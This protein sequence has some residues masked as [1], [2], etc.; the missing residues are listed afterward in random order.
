[1]FVFENSINKIIQLSGRIILFNAITFSCF[2]QTYF[3]DNYG[4][5]QGLESSKVFSIVQAKDDYIW[6]GTKAGV[7]K[8]NG[9][10]FQNYTIEDGLAKGGVRVVY[11]DKTGILWF[12][13]E[14][15]G[16]TRYDGKKF[17]N[18]NIT[19]TLPNLN[20]TSIVLT[21]DNNLWIC[22]SGDGVYRIFNPFDDFKKIKYEHFKGKKLGDNIFNSL[23]SS[24][25]DL[26]FITDYGIRKYMPETNSFQTYIP[27]GMDTYFAISILFEDSKKNLWFGTYNGGL[28]KHEYTS[29]NFSIIDTKAGLATNWISDITE[30]IY[31]NIWTGHWDQFDKGGISKIDTSGNITVFNTSNGMHDN[32][33]WC[34]IPDKEGNMLIGTTEHGFEIFKGEHFIS[35]TTEDGL[36]N[37]QVYAITQD[38][39]GKYWFGTKGGISVFD[40]KNKTF[41]NYNQDTR[42]ISNQIRFLK[43][44]SKGNLWIGTADQGIIRYDTKKKIF[45]Y[46]Q[47]IT[48][49]FYLDKPDNIPFEI[50]ALEIDDENN[51]WI[52][53]IERPLFY[54][55]ENNT[56]T[57]KSQEDGLP[58]NSITA[59]YID[60]KNRLWVGMNNK[61]IARNTKKGTNFLHVKSVGDITPTC[62]TEDKTGNIWIGT[63]SNGIFVLDDTTLIS[64]FTIH[65]GLL[66]NLINFLNVDE[67]NNIYV[68]TNIGLNKI[69][70]KENKIITYTKKSGFTGIESRDN[71]TFTDNKGKLWFGTGNG[72]ICYDPLIDKKPETEPLTHISNLLVNGEERSVTS[73]LNL[74][75]TEK[76]IT[77]VY[78]S[79]CL[80]DP[81]AVRYRIRLDGWETEWNDMGTQNSQIYSLPPGKYKF[82]V[83]AKNNQGIWNKN[84]ASLSFRI[85][86]PFYKSKGFII[87]TI[88]VLLFGFFSFIKIRERNLVREKKVLEDRVLER[89]NDLRKAN[90]QLAIRNKD[91]TDS[92]KYA[93][94]I[95]FSI[96]P[97]EIPFNNTFIFFKPKDIVSGD[98]YWLTSFKNKDFIAAVDCT[99]HGVPGAFMSFIGYTLLNKIVIENMVLEP[100]QILN[101]L[102]KEVAMTLHQKGEDIV[103]D[104]MDIALVCYDKLTQELEFAG[105][106]NPLWLMRKGELIEIKANR[107]AIGRLT[108]R[109]KEFTNHKLKIEPDDTI[110]LFSDGYC[111]QFGGPEGKKYKSGK[112]KELL[113]S[114]NQKSI[115]EQAK[116]LESSFE[117]WRGGHDQIDDVLFIGRRF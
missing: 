78:S 105:A 64:R 39:E 25:G 57:E 49:F 5:E 77:I 85:G 65:E 6:L 102:N 72:V 111:D 116:I 58:G 86:P 7:S 79:I 59:L 41:V 19:D 83:S 1:M 22:T 90:D 38:D 48:R 27:K 112:L 51:L 110:Y 75:H 4:S 20:V 82:N 21:S 108:G 50:T 23:V 107:F 43:K 10:S 2:A 63:A 69:K 44:D 53:T 67:E 16:I 114:I 32:K 100:G 35:F 98:F 101:Q 80:T 106:F 104:G 117:E 15:G 45:E 28:Y 17:E 31:G 3:F 18:L 103:N 87:S 55:I 97:P 95:Q 52:G 99:G 56:V 68:G 91:I 30:D 74:S 8:F 26:F 36:I 33:V 88:F 62:I 76:N 81:E 70:I 113:V 46:M 73:K 92:I 96:L 42:N 60:S 54:D 24:N 109:E 11:E 14:G 61:G 12:G 37:N 94:R 34:I 84:P 93:K 40:S 13:H 47:Y 71:A 66:T 89:T 9:T 115:D 29:G